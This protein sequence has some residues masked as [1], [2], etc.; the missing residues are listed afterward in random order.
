[1]PRP[2]ALIPWLVLIA[3]LLH[4]CAGGPELPDLPDRHGRGGMAAVT[5]LDERGEEAILAAGGCN[6]PEGPPWEGGVKR[7]YRDV[8]LLSRHDGVWTWSKVGELPHD[9]AYAAF[10]ATPDRRAMVIAGGCDEK[11]HHSATLVVGADGK[12]RTLAS[13]PAPRAFAGHASDGRT[14]LVVGGS[15]HPDAMR[16]ALPCL[17]LDLT[18]PSAGWTR[19]DDLG[20]W[21]ILPLVGRAGDGALIAS[22]CGLKEQ[23]GKPFRVYGSSVLLAQGSDRRESTLAR[24]IVAAAGPGVPSAGRL[25]FVGGDDGR[26][27]P[28]PPKDHPGLSRDI[29]AFDG[30]TPHVIGR[31]PEP[32]VTAPLLRLGNR[33][34]TVGGEDRPGHRTAKVSAWPLP[35]ERR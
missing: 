19:R 23:D 20:S 9:V 18:R 28:R 33:L 24:P 12:V 13:L 34:V 26:H 31:W 8:L 1:M 11:A 29:I 5:V 15:D 3:T 22:G 27:Y 16:T 35:A 25:I 14:L 30:M 17:E 21:G 32:V 4:G 10:T 2:S 7:Y 6:F